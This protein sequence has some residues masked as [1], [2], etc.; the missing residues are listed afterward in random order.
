M[1][2]CEPICNLK[3]KSGYEEPAWKGREQSI[4][5]TTNNAH[6]GSVWGLSVKLI[7]FDFH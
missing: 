1:N 3:S 4:I 6:I 2:H 7:Y 5:I